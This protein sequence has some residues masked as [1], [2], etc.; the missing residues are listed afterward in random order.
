MPGRFVRKN[1]N[2]IWVDGELAARIGTSSIM[3][4][5]P[6][7]RGVDVM[8]TFD[9][10]TLSCGTCVSAGALIAREIQIGACWLCRHP[11]YQFPFR[12]A[13]TH[14]LVALERALLCRSCG[15]LSCPKHVQQSAEGTWLC[16][17]CARK[18]RRREF[19]LSLFS[20]E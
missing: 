18:A 3:L 4:H 8:N 19:I 1:F 9:T 15:R 20:K 10:I 2:D 14:G 11:P 12:A 17:P 16:I 13:A 6:G 5:R 7:G